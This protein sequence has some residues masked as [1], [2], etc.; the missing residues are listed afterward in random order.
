VKKREKKKPIRDKKGRNLLFCLTIFSEKGEEE[1]F[2]TP[3]KRQQPQRKGESG[4]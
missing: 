1:T 4:F 2:S 3:F